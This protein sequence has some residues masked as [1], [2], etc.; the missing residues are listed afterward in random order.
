MG[1][2]AN[3]EP[4]EAPA[5]EPEQEAPPNP[6]TPEEKPEGDAAETAPAPEGDTKDYSA[7][8]EEL[9]AEVQRRVE[10]RAAKAEEAAL[11]KARQRVKEAD[12]GES[13]RHQ[14]YD[15]AE[16]EARQKA[17]ALRQLAVDGEV[18]DH[19]TLDA[20]MTAIMA[21]TV[22]ITAKD[23]EQAIKALV[24]S[25]LPE[26]TGTETEALE[27]LLYD[28]RRNGRFDKLLPKVTELAMARK[29]AEIADLK[30]QLGNRESV[31]AAAEKLANAAKAAG[32][33]AE[34]PQG[35]AVNSGP[36]TREEAETLPIEELKRRG[37]A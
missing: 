33:G 27:P 9:E 10:E 26:Q 36:L 24:D 34:T 13:S 14:L 29:D 32:V 18:I 19:K 17:A 7:I 37:Y 16:R 4:V 20:H 3:P 23:N 35:K 12:E 11:E 31:K 6:E 22:A 21:G 30:K 28:F 1:V 2:V 15:T 25:V 8:E 5:A